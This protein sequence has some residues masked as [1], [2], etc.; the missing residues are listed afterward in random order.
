LDTYDAAV[1][2]CPNYL[3]YEVAVLKSNIAACYLKMEDW[4]DAVNAATAALDGLDRLQGKIDPEKG[5]QGKIEGQGEVKEDGEEEEIE[6]IISEGA[7]K[8]EDTSEKGKREADIERIRAK[9]LMRR[10]R[11]RSEIGGWSTLQGAEDGMS[12]LSS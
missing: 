4:K 1:A 9:A 2:I 8:A 12:S 6:E 7:T 5:G 11:A 3:D 10:A